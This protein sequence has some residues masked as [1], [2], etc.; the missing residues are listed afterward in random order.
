MTAYWIVDI[1]VTDPAALETYKAKVPGIIARHG[2]KYL[3]V[4]GAHAITEGTWQPT[5]LVMICFPDRMALHAFLADPEYAPLKA[6]RLE[7]ATTHAIAVD[8]LA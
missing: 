4:G 5:F 1:N 6:L 7:S 8:G 3:V 2:G